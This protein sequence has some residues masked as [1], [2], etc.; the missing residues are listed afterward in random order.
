MM[1]RLPSISRRGSRWRQTLVLISTS[2]RTSRC[3]TS[4]QSRLTTFW[5]LLPCWNLNWEPV[6]L[7]SSPCPRWK[8][9]LTTSPI[10]WNSRPATSKVP[11]RWLFQRDDV[12]EDGPLGQLRMCGWRQGIRCEGLHL[13]HHDPLGGAVVRQRK[14]DRRAEHAAGAADTGPARHIAWV[15]E[16]G[17]LRVEGVGALD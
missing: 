8:G 11:N 6:Q 2:P 12:E 13:A 1:S 7:P 5:D 9:P 15:A 4:T 14:A 17:E 16:S 3:S 10:P